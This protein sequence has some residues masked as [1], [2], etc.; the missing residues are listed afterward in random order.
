MRKNPSSPFTLI[1][2]G[3]SGDLTRRKLIPAVFNLYR[4]NLLPEEFSPQCVQR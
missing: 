3:A 4:Q 1:I 2:F